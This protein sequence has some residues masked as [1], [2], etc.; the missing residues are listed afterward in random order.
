MVSEAVK[1]YK[2]SLDEALKTYIE[3]VA[4]ESKA[5]GEAERVLKDITELASIYLKAL[6]YQEKLKEV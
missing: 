2:K 6:T 1:A 5:R 3:A 4:K